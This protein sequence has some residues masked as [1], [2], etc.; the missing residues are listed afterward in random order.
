M[1]FN[2]EPEAFVSL[3]RAASRI[4][5]PIAWL[6]AEAEAD[7]VPHLRVSRRLMFNVAEVERVLL[8]RAQG[9]PCSPRAPA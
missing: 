4:G 7:R 6:K 8:D 1:S 5:V 3:R 2:D 9:H